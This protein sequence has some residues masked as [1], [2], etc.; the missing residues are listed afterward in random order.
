[1]K[2]N[3]IINS[4]KERIK[5]YNV[6]IYGTIRDVEA[7]F[8]SSFINLEMIGGM[9]NKVFYVILENDSSDNTRT[10]LK[11]W[12]GED[13]NK[14]IILLDNLHYYFPL[15]AT[16]LAFCRNEIL[17]FMRESS[18]EEDYQFAIHC[19]LDNRFWSLNPDSICHF[20]DNSCKDDWDMMSAVSTSRSYYDYWALRCEESWFTRNIFSCANEGIRY[21]SKIE[22]FDSILK[23]T[24]NPI[25]VQSSF[26]GMAI[27]KIK[28]LLASNYN[29]SYYCNVCHNNNESCRE[30]NDHIGLH[31]RMVYNGCKLFV[32]N[33]VEIHSRK[34][35][36]LPYNKFI[37]QI[38]VTDIKKNMITWLIYTEKIDFYKDVLFLGNNIALYANSVSKYYFE[39]NS[40]KKIYYLGKEEYWF[41]NTNVERII[42]FDEFKSTYFSL[43]YISER[44]YLE[45]TYL[46]NQ[47]KGYVSTGTLII[48][49]DF[50]NFNDFHTKVFKAFYEF[51]QMN[52]IN[53]KWVITNSHS[54]QYSICIEV[55]E[56]QNITQDDLLINYNSNEYIEFDWIRYTNTY[57]DLAHVTSK[58]NAFKH[59]LVYGQEEGREYFKKEQTI[60]LSTLQ[61]QI[62]MEENFDWEMYLDLNSDLREN[63]LKNEVDAINHWFKHGKAENRKYK[64]DWCKYI[65]NNNLI[66]LNIDNK[67]K[68]IE[69]WKENDC[70]DQDE[71]DI[72]DDLFD[73]QYYVKNN[74]DLSHLSHYELA[75]Q[76][77]DL[78]G[79]KEGRKCH[80]FSWTEYLMENPELV[81]EGIDSEVKA[82]LH[83][84][85]NHK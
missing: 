31:K 37:E 21:E 73:W 16:R 57:S 2:N 63:G 30:D 27:Y 56:V 18:F 83:W 23:N 72:N 77:W 85:S 15:R 74:S 5:N 76:H 6:V 17:K 69:H 80:A 66:V 22:T 32:N 34:E 3:L 71:L 79:R 70:P 54:E 14:K 36:Y 84:K 45:A 46:L 35:N 61:S 8:L 50:F 1:M 40:N 19:D 51:V 28:S 62:I 52:H 44:N 7:D 58:D 65:E 67:E 78:H 59:W 33:K 47:I 53:F 81:D 38:N 29:S 64:F 13:K 10:L 49:T 60:T 41:L 43:I 26:N 20:F 25:P 68:A 4:I 42:N 75:K 39:N 82:Y 11:K 24:E 55:L 48:F 9:F 12:A